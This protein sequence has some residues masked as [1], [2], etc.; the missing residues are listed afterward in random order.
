MINYTELKWVS[1]GKSIVQCSTVTNLSDFPCH[2]H[3]SLCH[4]FKN[5]HLPVTTLQSPQYWNIP[6]ERNWQGLNWRVSFSAWLHI[7]IHV[8]IHHVIN[9]LMNF[10][11]ATTASSI[12][13]GQNRPLHI[14]DVTCRQWLVWRLRTCLSHVTWDTMAIVEF[15]TRICACLVPV[16]DCSDGKNI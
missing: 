15:V 14:D 6:T 8:E 12:C 1:R 4:I 11:C 3:R 7:F 10:V 13:C 16:Q 9:T 5:T 2:I